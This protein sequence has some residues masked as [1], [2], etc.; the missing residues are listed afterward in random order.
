MKKVLALLLAAVMVFSVAACGQSERADEN[1][2]GKTGTAA[3]GD[4]TGE[5][6]GKEI[7]GEISYMHFGDDYERQMYEDLIKGYM[8]KNPKAKINQI[9]TPDDY[10][11]KLQTMLSSKTTPDVFWFAEGRTAEYAK[12]GIL[13]DLTNVYEKYPALVEDL[14][15]SLRKFGQYEGKDIAMVKDWTSYVM[16]LN[17]DMFKEAGVTPPTSDWT[18]KD[19]IEIAGKMTKKE[20]DR[21]KQYGV[22]VNNYRADWIAWLGANNAEWFKNGKVNFSDPKS[23]EGLRPMFEAVEK[24]YAP[25]PAVL[26]SMGTTEDRMFITGMVAMYPSGRWVI[27]SFRGECDFEWDAVELPTAETKSVAFICGMIGISKDS[28]NKDLAADFVAYQLSREGLKYVSP[29]ALALPAYKSVLA[30]PEYVTVPPS[31]EPFLKSADY[32]GTDVQYNALMSGGFSKLNDII[33]A[34]LSSAYNGDITLE[35]AC[36]NIDSKANGDIFK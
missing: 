33:Y 25:S 9:Y 1:N 16:Y 23:I 26:S 24:G 7:S 21:V 13:E 29:S 20:G 18:M 14:I 3:S 8:A 11:T 31:T 2:T 17:L 10:Y 5:T 30:D 6:A 28:K 22:C 32:V 15:P 34:E 35:Q 12:A 27:P 36:K 19:Y 4:K